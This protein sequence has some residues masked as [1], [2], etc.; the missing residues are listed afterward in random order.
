MGATQ[1]KQSSCGRYRDPEPT[2]REHRRRSKDRE[3][4]VARELVIR[5]K[6]RRV[7]SAFEC[8]DDCIDRALAS[9]GEY[10]SSW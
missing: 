1:R 9:L 6:D 7:I 8:C 3:R 5:L 4:T 10:E 2:L